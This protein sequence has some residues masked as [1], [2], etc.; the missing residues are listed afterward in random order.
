MLTTI[1]EKLKPYS[2]RLAALMGACTTFLVQN[3][4]LLLTLI[5]F[6]PVSPVPRFLFAA[7]VGGAVFLVPY[8]ARYWP[9]DI[10]IAKEDSNGQ[11]TK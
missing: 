1:I 9:Q 11:A 4:D 7:V 10:S 2:I 5:A 8:V 3:S 6:I